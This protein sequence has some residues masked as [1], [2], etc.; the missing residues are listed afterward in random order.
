M[1]TGKT[2]EGMVLEGL[3][4]VKHSIMKVPLKKDSKVAME[5]SFSRTGID[6]K[7]STLL[8]SSTA[9]DL[10]FGSMDRLMKDSLRKA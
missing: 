2:T 7:V 1:V 6:T 3:L 10:T 5:S 9:K 8:A 4:L